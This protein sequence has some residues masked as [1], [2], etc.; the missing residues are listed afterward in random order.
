MNPLDRNI[1]NMERQRLAA[2]E[3]DP[4]YDDT[5]EAWEDE[6]EE[7]NEGETCPE[8]DEGTLDADDECSN[9]NCP[10]N[11]DVTE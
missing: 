1:R 8:C 11:I 9:P 6:D 7:E 3:D 10:S 4:A 5:D 2:P